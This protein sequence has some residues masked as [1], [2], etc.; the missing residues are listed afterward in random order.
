MRVSGNSQWQSLLKIFNALKILM[1]VGLKFED[2]NFVGSM[3][4]VVYSF[5]RTESG[6]QHDGVGVCATVE[7][8]YAAGFVSFLHV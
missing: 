1:A 7:G 3:F 2:P 8:R 4:E 5:V 6:V